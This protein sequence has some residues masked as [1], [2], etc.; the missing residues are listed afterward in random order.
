MDQYKGACVHGMGAVRTCPMHR[1]TFGPSGGRRV[2]HMS[3][4]FIDKRARATGRR[5]GQR[6][7]D[8]SSARTGERTTASQHRDRTLHHPSRDRTEPGPWQGVPMRTRGIGE[9]RHR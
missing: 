4:H 9:R 8:E 6:R 2:H 7:R 1:L 5:Q 3:V